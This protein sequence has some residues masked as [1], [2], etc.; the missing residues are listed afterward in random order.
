MWNCN[1]PTAK[2]PDRRSTWLAFSLKKKKLTNEDTC[3]YILLNFIFMLGIV[4]KV[5]IFFY[6]NMLLKVKIFIL[7]CNILLH[8]IVIWKLQ[9]SKYEQIVIEG[10]FIMLAYFLWILLQLQNFLDFPAIKKVKTWFLHMYM[11]V[12]KELL[13]VKLRVCNYMYKPLTEEWSTSTIKEL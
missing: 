2:C 11:Y 6:Q 4:N 13:Y 1:K 5:A 10:I 12:S 7:H 9:L 3:K 8:F